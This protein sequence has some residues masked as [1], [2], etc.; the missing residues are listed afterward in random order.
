MTDT[1]DVSKVWKL[2]AKAYHNTIGIKAYFT[3]TKL[4]AIGLPAVT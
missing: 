4:D 3:D 1:E 2:G